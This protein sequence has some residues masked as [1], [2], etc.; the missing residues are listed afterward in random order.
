M[1][2]SWLTVNMVT[3]LQYIWRKEEAVRTAVGRLRQATLPG[4]IAYRCLA[5]SGMCNL[6]GLPEAVIRSEVGRALSAIERP[7]GSAI[8]RG[9]Q[10]V[11]DVDCRRFEFISLK[12]KSDI[13]SRHWQL[14]VTRFH[15]SSLRAGFHRFTAGHLHGA[16][17]EMADNAL[18]HS[19]AEFPIVIGYHVLAGFAQFCVADV[20]IGVLASLR[21]CPDYADLKTDVEAIRKALQDGVSRYGHQRGGCGFRP[22]FKAVAAQWGLLRFRSGE[23]CLV[24]DGTDCSADKAKESF[25]P[26]VPGFHVTVSSS[27]SDHAPIAH[28]A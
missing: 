26:F 5:W 24:I 28:V 3:D 8:L 17:G 13:Q 11:R 7:A 6:P 21:Q 25:P 18:S 14:F 1:D 23:G 15:R 22:V 10:D 20:G 4:I 16:L 12:E 27:T 9:R 2:D 19:N